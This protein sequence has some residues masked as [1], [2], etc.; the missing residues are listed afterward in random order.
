M[1]EVLRTK[2]KKNR[3]REPKNGAIVKPPT[4]QFSEGIAKKKRRF[5]L[6]GPLFPY[7]LLLFQFVSLRFGRIKK[8]KNTIFQ[9]EKSKR[10]RRKEKEAVRIAKG[11]KREQKRNE[12]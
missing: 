1:M 12:E 2:N 3:K 9:N 4:P 6:G 11:R 7:F 10:K 8:N 5:I